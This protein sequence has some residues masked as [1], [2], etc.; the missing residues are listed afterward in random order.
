MS[1]PQPPTSATCDLHAGALAA[2][3][4]GEHLAPEEQEQLLAHL[5]L[6]AACRRRLDHYAT[7][8]RLLPLVAPEAAPGPE[9]RGRIIAAAARG[10]APV[11]T[12][13]TPAPRWRRLLRPALALALVALVALGVVQS[14][15]VGQLEAQIAEQQ[16]R[17]AA[18]GRLVI[19]A[20]GN[21]DAVEIALEATAAAPDASGRAFVSPGEPAAAIYARRL[22]P[23]PA[24][25]EY[26]V[27]VEHAGGVTSAGR[28]TVNDEG[29]AWRPLRPEAPLGTVVRVFVTAEP[30]G[31][32]PQPTG[33]EVLSG[34]PR[35]P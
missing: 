31:G 2:L 1:T 25:Q 26:Q 32:S 34:A 9:L 22:P 24:D 12:A 6:C 19:A 21:E 13:R 14:A 35:Q 5:T 16:A 7:V 30:A 15:R 29:R 10:S 8:A 4:L 11:A 17:T 27:W 33:A 18:N 23:L 3:T 28:I 20:F